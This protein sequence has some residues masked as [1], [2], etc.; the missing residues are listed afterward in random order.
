[1]R[2]ARTGICKLAIAAIASS[3]SLQVML[4]AGILAGLRAGR[5]S[6]RSSVLPP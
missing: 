5:N 6:G 1:M 3:R 2:R 4:H